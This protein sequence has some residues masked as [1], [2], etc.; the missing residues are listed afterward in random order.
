M[1][2]QRKGLMS[3]EIK[4]NSLKAIHPGRGLL[5]AEGTVV[6]AGSRIGFTTGVVIDGSGEPV[7]TVSSTLLV[8]DVSWPLLRR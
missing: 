4:V 6:K 3:V 1:L 7:A 5:R 2:P 8:F